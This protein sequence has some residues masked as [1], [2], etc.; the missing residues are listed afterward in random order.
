V[1][2][3]AVNRGWAYVDDPVP[4]LPGGRQVVEGRLRIDEP[5]SGRPSPEGQVYN[6]NAG[7][8]VGAA[9]LEAQLEGVPVLQGVV[10]LE[11]PGQGLGDP[12]LPER[13]LGNHLSYAFQWWF[14]AAAIPV[15]LVILARREA[16]DEFAMAVAGVGAPRR[17]SGPTD[18]ELEDRLV[19]GQLVEGRQ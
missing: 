2:A 12:V 19:E 15:G 11:E 4:S 3:V 10:Q 14:F 1:V 9:G 7:D 6:Y 8:V 17:R 18:E 13:S 5:A 16:M